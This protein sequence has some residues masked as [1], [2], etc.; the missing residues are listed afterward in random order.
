MSWVGTG[1]S[2]SPRGE[3]GRGSDF[4]S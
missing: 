2:F 4:S 3:G 1:N